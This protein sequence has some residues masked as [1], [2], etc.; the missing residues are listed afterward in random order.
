MAVIDYNRVN[1]GTVIY[2]S[3]KMLKEFF[4]KAYNFMLDKNPTTLEEFM[5]M[6]HKIDKKT[7][8]EE[9]EKELKELKEFA[10]KNEAISKDFELMELDD[11]TPKAIFNRYKAASWVI[12]SNNQS[13]NLNHSTEETTW[14]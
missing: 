7:L 11:E 4:P 14:S 10:N 6:L 8:N 1:D 2:L 9:T 13:F 3:M 12:I 5:K